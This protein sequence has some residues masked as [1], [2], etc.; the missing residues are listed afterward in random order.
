MKK[1][2]QIISVILCALLAVSVFSVGA[3]AKKA[4]KFVKSIKVAKSASIT[5]PSGKSSASK[6]FKVTVK[7]KGKASKK[8]TAKSAN[9]SVA[10]VKVSGSKIVVTAKKAGTAK[11]KV[12]TK[13]KNKK[14]KK[15]SATLTV[16]VKKAAASKS[17]SSAAPSNT[18]PGTTPSGNTTPSGTTPTVKPRDLTLS[19]VVNKVTRKASSGKNDQGE[20][21]VVD[22]FVN[23]AKSTFS[24]TPISIEELKALHKADEI[25]PKEQDA[26]L[27]T[28]KANGRFEVVALYFAAL[29]A[30]DPKNPKVCFDMME[31]L[32]ESPTYKISQI[33]SFNAFSENF[34]KVDAFGKTGRLQWKY[35]YVGNAYFDGANPDN[36]YTPSEP[37]TVTLEDYVYSSEY[38]SDA[39]S[40]VYKI[41]SRFKGADSE[42]IIQVYQ[43]TIDGKWYIFSDSWK[44]FTADMKEPA[45]S[46][47]A[48]WQAEESK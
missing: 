19:T 20:E 41:V 14:K 25:L 43:D 46:Y 2:R 9:A 36:G 18:K 40:Y 30:Y 39:Q 13:A 24:D 10:A 34:L 16:T 31:E 45:I 26:A 4:K 11:I 32:C 5:I 28:D 47:I 42:R 21:T 8:F 22:V 15:L 33:N 29:K 38:S 23:Q 44:G 35:K 37:K 48:Q 27:N 12:T 6:S 7:V 3:S 1:S 17:N